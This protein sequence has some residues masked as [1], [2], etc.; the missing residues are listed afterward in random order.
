MPPGPARELFEGYLP[1]GERKLGQN[2][3]PRAIL[4][5][6]GDAKRGQEVFANSR[7]QCVSCHQID[8]KGI[9]IGPDLS[10]IGKDRTREQLLQSILEPSRV[11]EAKYQSCT[12]VTLDGKTVTGIITRSDAASV[13]IRDATGKD[14]TIGKD[15]VELQKTSPVSLMATGL[16]AD[17]TPQQAADLLEFLATRK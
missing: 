13:T 11:V 7:N 16:M 6:A 4:S 12:I 17:L 8:G 9:A 14:H 1:S 5:L 10:R 3:R 2:P 15:N